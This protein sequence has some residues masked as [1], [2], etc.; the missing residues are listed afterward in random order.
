[1]VLHL[2]INKINLGHNYVYDPLTW[3]TKGILCMDD[4]VLIIT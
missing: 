4:S 2:I 1:M 3:D